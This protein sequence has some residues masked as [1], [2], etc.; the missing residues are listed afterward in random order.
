MVAPADEIGYTCDPIRH[1]LLFES[2]HARDVH[3]A[4]SIRLVYEFMNIKLAIK[5]PVPKFE[6]VCILTNHVPFTTLDHQY[7]RMR[8]AGS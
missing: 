6:V 1:H 7:S 5:Y 3:A 4:A 2:C 8:I